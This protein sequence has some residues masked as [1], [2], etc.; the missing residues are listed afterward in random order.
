MSLTI[1]MTLRYF[2]FA[3]VLFT[4]V[5]EALAAAPKN[6]TLV[7]GSSPAIT[8][9]GNGWQGPGGWKGLEPENEACTTPAGLYSWGTNAACTP[10]EVA[11][12]TVVF[13][14]TGIYFVGWANSQNGVYQ[15]YL[16]GASD[17]PV[18]AYLPPGTGYCNVI[19]YQ[20]TGLPSGQHNLTMALLPDDPGNVGY[21]EIAVSGFIV[22]TGE[23]PLPLSS[24]PVTSKSTST[25]ASLSSTTIASVSASSISSASTIS[26][27]VS[28]GTTSALT[29][30]IA[31][32]SST[33][34]A[35]ASSTSVG[36][37]SASSPPVSS[38]ITSVS[39][40][41][42]ASLSSTTITS[43]PATS[44]GASSTTSPAVSS[45]ATSTST[46]TFTKQSV[47]R[48]VG[49][50]GKKS[51]GESSLAPTGTG[52]GSLSTSTTTSTVSSSQSVTSSSSSAG[53]GSSA[54]ATTTSSTTTSSTT[55][56]QVRGPVTN[57]GGFSAENPQTTPAAASSTSTT[58]SASR[59]STIFTNRPSISG[60]VPATSVTSTSVLPTISKTSVVA[61]PVPTSD[62]ASVSS[63][64]TA[65]PT[66]LSTP[67]SQRS[68]ASNTNTITTSSPPSL[69]SAS[70]TSLS[71]SSVPSLPVTTMPPSMTTT[72][73]IPPSSDTES[74]V[75]STN[76]NGSSMVSLPNSQGT[77]MPTQTTAAQA[78]PLPQ[79]E[80]ATLSTP[81]GTPPACPT[82]PI[83]SPS[84]GSPPPSFGS[85]SDPA[86]HF[87]TTHKSPARRKGVIAGSVIGGIAGLA[88]L[89]AFLKFLHWL[90]EI[91]QAK[92]AAK[93][94]AMKSKTREFN[95]IIPP[96]PPG[97]SRGNSTSYQI[98]LTLTPVDI[99]DNY[100][101]KEVVWQREK[102]IPNETSKTRTYTAKLD[103][104]RA[105]GTAN[106][107]TGGDIINGVSYC[108]HPTSFQHAKPGRPIPFK[109]HVWSNPLQFI[110]HK[111]TRIIARNDD[112]VPLRLVIGSYVR[113][114]D[115][116][117]SIHSSE[118]GEYHNLEE[119]DRNGN[120]KISGFQP[121]VI[122]D[123]KIQ[124]AQQISA[125]LDLVL[126]IYKTQDV[127]VG[128]ILSPTYLKRK[129]VPLLGEGGIKLSKLPRVATWVVDTEGSDVRLRMEKPGWGH[130]L[131]QYL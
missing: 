61:V 21:P 125:S 35:P 25:T 98:A 57:A 96:C 52:S 8:F 40:T 58:A 50:A 28:S 36:S 107:R 110:A 48:P 41:T 126:R 130:F 80:P 87:H 74:S 79:S 94:G 59:F 1:S 111:Y 67:T 32:L 115:Q 92:K 108:D 34:I 51:P 101:Y 43:A 116:P 49:G 91:S 109:G 60:S 64:S 37:S 114:E 128:Q 84:S 27:P 42:I 93:P 120:E 113:P 54:R 11:S 4:A 85:D 55:S 26:H 13:Q 39:T 82:L 65:P 68:L 15:P 3:L 12:V 118:Y 119:G 45:N 71:A 83:A 24:I 77:P 106:I 76:L 102:V 88:A 131:Y 20:K 19:Q 123:D 70:L 103:Y 16:D 100:T 6:T 81:S 69:S 44:V 46:E 18:S 7:A 38:G 66:S 62:A 33:T 5:P 99:E 89:I 105:F 30:T 124:Y 56:G 104:D 63:P 121:F 86:A 47:K 72:A 17:S 90:R 9:T 75:W 97:T 129:A 22:T 10:G 31:S 2:L 29:S 95:F 73:P 53:T 122:M 23:E 117:V 78:G 14:G 127:E 112:H